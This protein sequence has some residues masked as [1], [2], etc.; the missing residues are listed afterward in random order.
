MKLDVYS[1]FGNQ[2]GKIKPN[3]MKLDPMMSNM[4]GDL[5]RT[6]PNGYIGFLR[7]SYRNC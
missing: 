2:K 4:V 3:S 5:C 7:P 6:Q 1:K